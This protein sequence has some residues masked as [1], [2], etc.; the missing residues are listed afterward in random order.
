ML[1]RTTLTITLFAASLPMAAAADPVSYN[2]DVR[3]ILS[4]NCFRCHGPDENDRK[5]KMRL[6]VPGEADLEE[7]IARI[8]ETDPDE[9]MPPPASNKT[10]TAEQIEIIKNWIAQGAKYEQHW[11]FVLPEKPKIPAGVAAIDHRIPR[12]PRRLTSSRSSAAS[13]ST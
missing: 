1:A 7:V 9:I 13:T 4:N 11:A 10:L 5:A 12:P 8:V 2:R 6:D 3:P